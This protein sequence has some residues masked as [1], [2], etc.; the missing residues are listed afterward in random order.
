MHNHQQIRR[1]F[2]RGYAEALDFLRQSRQ[3]LRH[4]VLHLHLGFVE[5]GTQSEGDRQ[6]HHAVGGGLRKTYTACLRRH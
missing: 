3:R 2:F 1:G 4:T 5:V 6:S